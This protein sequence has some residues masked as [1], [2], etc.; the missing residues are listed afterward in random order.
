MPV[1]EVSSTGLFGVGSR[2]EEDGLLVSDARQGLG[3]RG[4]RVSGNGM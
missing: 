4:L 2:V 1:K 3:A